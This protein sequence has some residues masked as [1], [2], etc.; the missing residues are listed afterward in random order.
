VGRRK[1]KRKPKAKN[2]DRKRRPRRTLTPKPVVKRVNEDELKALIERARNSTLSEGEC[3]ELRGVVET[4]AFVVRELDEKNL[5]LRRLRS[6]FGLSNS[7]KLSS[8]LPAAE[9]DTAGER[10]ATSE[11][12]DSAKDAEEEPPKGHGRNGA[13]AYTGAERV[14][15]PHECLGSG[16]GCPSCG[17]GKVYEQRHRPRLLVRVEG[18]P[19]LKATVYELQTFRC[20]LCG[21][22]FVAKPPDGVSDAK[23][24]ATSAAMIGLLKYGSGLPSY[25][26]ERLEKHLGIPLPASTQWDVAKEAASDLGPVYEELI[27]VA[28]QGDLLHNDDSSMRVLSLMKENDALRKSGAAKAGTRTG[29]FVTGIVS[30]AMGLRVALFFTG[31]KHA[32]ENLQDVLNE[33]S[34]ELAPPLQMSDGLDR[35]DPADTETVRGTCLAHGRRKFV[36]VLESFPTECEHVLK[37]I[38]KVYKHDADSFALGHSAED[39][40]AHHVKHSQSIMD[41]LEAC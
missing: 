7:E 11:S 9:P 37:E 38:A 16:D 29:I 33:R 3:D 41:D 31:R 28:A 32:G 39:R 22:I 26:I 40:L 10:E 2:R 1:P 19:P 34:L 18:Q 13:D 15:V 25:R 21:E 6:L 24:D 4:L 20:N 27:R 23:Y 35:N 17:R 30:I 8:I 14:E 36:E 5:S 12:E